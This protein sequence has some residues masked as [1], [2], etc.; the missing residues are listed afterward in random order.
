MWLV[1]FETRAGR[2][3]AP[4]GRGGSGLGVRPE[5]PGPEADAASAS[6]SGAV[7]SGRRRP[8]APGSDRL[9]AA[10]EQVGSGRGPAAGAEERP[11]LG[12]QFTKTFARGEEFNFVLSVGLQEIRHHD[13]LIYLC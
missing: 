11:R 12:W 5:G 3:P 8:L 6:P 4:T 9:R 2:P 10:A 1:R 13:L 7:A